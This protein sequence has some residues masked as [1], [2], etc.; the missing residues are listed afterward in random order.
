MVGER[1]VEL[2][3]QRQD[4]EGHRP[5]YG[6]RGMATHTVACIDCDLQRA[7]RSQ[8]DQSAEVARVFL[9]D[10][11]GAGGACRSVVRGNTRD[12]LGGDDCEAGVLTDRL[13]AGPTHLDAV[14]LGGIVARREHRA[15]AVQQTGCKV[16]LVGRRQSDVD[17]VEPLS[18]HAVTESRRQCGRRCAHVVADH[19]RRGGAG[20]VADQAGERRTDVADKIFVDLLTDHTAYVVRLDDCSNR[21]GCSPH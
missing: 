7:Q 11:L 5:E 4:V 8:V 10:V 2:E 12:D 9:E 18:K 1:A 21:L 16:E 6:R 19:N 14:V 3:V 15:R 20:L 13:G 17:D